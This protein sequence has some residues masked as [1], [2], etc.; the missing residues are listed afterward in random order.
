MVL[1]IKSVGVVGLGKMGGP[2][3][4]HLA[5]K[6]FAVVGYDVDRERVEAAS[7]DG[8]AVAE[9]P[10]DLAAKSDLVIVVVGFDSEVDEA[11]FGPKGSVGAAKD[12]A[13]IAVAST[14]APGF[15]RSL[16]DRAEERG[17]TFLDIPLCRGEK[18]AI[19]G[20]LLIMG[21]GEEAAFEACRPAFATFADA[22]FHLGPLGAGQV[23]K[24]VNNLIL[25]TCIS[26]N[27]EG[28]KLAE[29]LGVEGARLR[30]ALLQSSAGNWALET[31]AHLNPMPWAEKDMT[32]VLKEA[33]Q[34]A[35]SLPLSGV[36][37][38]VI[39]G[40]KLAKGAPI[41]KPRGGGG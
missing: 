6:G 5:A 24:M 20:K 34:A 32:I 27:V 37:K 41:P 30:E 39:K 15:M 18:P 4:R 25:W 33:D 28:M 26:G 19:E 29:A 12:G 3:S 38:E 1:D 10:A 22:I 17:V 16:P 8:V 13:V 2:I 7:S 11:L 35:L 40:I 14:V 31:Q 21:G 9:S 36:V 23:G